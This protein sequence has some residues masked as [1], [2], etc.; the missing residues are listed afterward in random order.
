[1]FP[2]KRFYLQTVGRFLPTDLF[3]P[4]FPVS[5]KGICFMEGKVILVQN[6]HSEWDLPGGKLGFGESLEECLVREM[7]EE[8]GIKVLPVELID[9]LKV[10]VRGLISVLIPVYSCTTEATCQDL[11]LSNEHF[12]VHCFD[13]DELSQLIMAVEYGPLIQKALAKG[14]EPVP[15]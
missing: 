7:K 5:L 15:V 12:K 3:A 8:L 1:M 6:E 2:L 11:V 10:N 13:P 9:L 4:R 14:A